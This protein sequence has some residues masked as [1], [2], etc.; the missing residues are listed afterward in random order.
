[1]R[2]I[3]ITLAL[4]G[5]FGSLVLSNASQAAGCPQH[6]H[7]CATPH[8]KQTPCIS[9]HCKQHFAR[10]DACREKIADRIDK[11][12]NPTWCQKGYIGVLQSPAPCAGPVAP[13]SQVAP[14]G[15]IAPAGQIAPTGQG[16]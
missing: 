4:A 2:R 9:E 8:R 1:M 7:G 3:V 12:F 13:S 11:C 15:Q 16:S 6:G 10:W 5:L 14:T